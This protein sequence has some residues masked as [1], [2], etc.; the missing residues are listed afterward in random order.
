MIMTDAQ[1]KEAVS[2][3]A[4]KIEPFDEKNLQPAT[5]DLRV[6][7]QAITTSTKSIVDLTKQGFVTIQPG[8]VGVVVSYERLS[9][10]P[11][12]AGR[13]GLRSY[14]ARAGLFATTGPQIDPGWSGRLMIGVLNLTPRPITLSY[15]DSFLSVEFHRLERDVERP[16]DGPYQGRDKLGPEEIRFVT[17]QEGVAFS[18]VIQGIRALSVNVATLTSEVRA[19][20]WMVPVIFGLALAMVAWVVGTK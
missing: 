18:E 19:L 9:L 15:M 2:S 17:E 7:P 14:Y 4:I 16:Y 12:Y 6:G 3:G 8:D 11:R 13:F 5:Y 10:S 20:K 1:I